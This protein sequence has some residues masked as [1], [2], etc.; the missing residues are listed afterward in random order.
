[1]GIGKSGQERRRGRKIGYQERWAPEKWVGKE[2]GIRKMGGKGSGHREKWVPLIAPPLQAVLIFLL[3]LLFPFSSYLWI[4]LS[5][6]RTFL[7]LIILFSRCLWIIPSTQGTILGNPP[8]PLLQA[9]LISLLFLFFLLFLLFPFSS[10]LWIAPSMQGTF[11]FLI[12][13]FSSSDIPI[14]PAGNVRLRDDPGYERNSKSSSSISSSPS[15]APAANPPNPKAP[16][17]DNSPA[18]PARP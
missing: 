12:I 1:M 10:Y 5:M 4:A 8:L 18:F 14:F 2:L 7:F 16:F 3:F 15:P 11:L 13:L 9:T 6:Q 17:P